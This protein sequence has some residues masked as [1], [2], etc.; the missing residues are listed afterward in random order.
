MIQIV[1]IGNNLEKGNPTTILTLSNLLISNGFKV[2]CYSQVK[3]KVGRLFHMIYG[4]FK[5]QSSNFLMIDTY[6]TQNF[7]YALFVSQLARFLNMKY[8][9]ILHGGNL[10]NR[11]EKNAR[12]SRLLFGNS[13][14]NIAPSNYLLTKF[15]EYN[16]NT[17]FIPNGIELK[18]YTYKK[19]ATL[20]PTLLWVRAFDTIY[21]P[22]M[23]IKVLIELKKQ[24][25]NAKL[26]MVGPDKD[27]SLILA[28][29]LA[30]EVGVMD[31]IEF[32]G[33]LEKDKWIQK[34]NDYDIFINT[35]TIDNTPVSVIEAMALGMPIVST[36]VGGIP[37]LIN[38]GKDGLL[39]ENND[40][41][42]MAKAV[43]YLIENP[44]E[45]LRLSKKAKEKVNEFDS[46][47]V[48]KQWEILLN[49]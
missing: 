25:P 41:S 32:T 24:Y 1:Y 43:S 21:N 16:F 12:M 22:K 35:T 5:N 30:E 6:S 28:K 7:Y 14:V 8:I 9:P 4:V 48:K 42:A 39:V 26:C 10:P 40:K 34:S 31:D 45:A 15:R 27:G 19:R 13:F 44:E 29:K 23:A 3:N 38:S 2:R 20:Q 49:T 47:V 36:N 17:K 33:Y 37:Y 46:E 18:N 11:L